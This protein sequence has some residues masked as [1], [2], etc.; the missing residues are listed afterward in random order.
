VSKADEAIDQ[1]LALGDRELAWIGRNEGELSKLA[2]LRQLLADDEDGML[3]ETVGLAREF[4]Q[5]HPLVSRAHGAEHRRVFCEGEGCG[6]SG[7]PRRSLRS[8]AFD[9]ALHDREVLLDLRAMATEGD[10][11]RDAPKS[12][13][14][15]TV[16]EVIDSPAAFDLTKPNAGRPVVGTVSEF[17]A[18]VA[19]IDREYAQLQGAN[20]IDTEGPTPIDGT[21][22][23]KTDEGV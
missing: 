22:I 20:P 17:D 4:L 16:C 12:E 8:L 15:P 23:A 9:S 19:A 10:P 14:P 2:E 5:A 3:R 13:R 18:S 11:V 21:R 7:P 6:W 1:L